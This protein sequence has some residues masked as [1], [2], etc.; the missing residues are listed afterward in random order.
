MFRPARHLAVAVMLLALALLAPMARPAQTAGV[1]LAQPIFLPL[2]SSGAPTVVPGLP[3]DPDA[4]RSGEATFYDA[5]GSGN[6]SFPA[7][8][9]NLLVAA[10]NHVDYANAWL[11]GAFV[12]ISGPQGNVV[13]RIVDQCPECPAGNIDLSA[14]AFALIAEPVQGRVLITWKIVSPPLA[15]PIVY[16]FKEGSSQYWTAVQIRNHRNP[17]H[18]VAY[19]T[20]GGTFKALARVDYNYFIEARGMGPGP[21]TFRVTDIYG[22]TLEDSGVP[23]VVAGDAPGGG[24]FPAR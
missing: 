21:Y 5:D 14:E 8:P 1:A 18:S 6:C 20:P 17:V 9:A 10:M 22:N 3:S 16:H 12:Q 13:V 4:T 11:C 2:I 7:T 23:L 19:R 15:G 24:Q